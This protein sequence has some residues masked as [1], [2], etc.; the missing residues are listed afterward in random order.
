MTEEKPQ[1]P[2]SMIKTDSD[3]VP[4]VSKLA[5]E[6]KNH[7]NAIIGF[8]QIMSD[9][10]RTTDSVKQLKRWSEIVHVEAINLAKT[11]ERILDEE[12]SKVTIVEK[13]FIDFNV[14][15]Q[16]IVTLFQEQAKKQGVTLSLQICKNF[17]ILHTDPVL[18]TEMLNNLLNNAIKFTPK[19][20]KVF[21]KGEIDMASKALILVVQDTGKGISSDI[22]MAIQR[23]EQVTTSHDKTKFKGWGLGMQIIAEN[24]RKVGCNFEL[25]CPKDKG[26]VACLKFPPS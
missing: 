15:G 2:V 10:K 14:F 26:T 4:T 17:P 3:P 25:Y 12:R 7:L 16:K 8:T 5:H 23:G 18:L 9:P 13:E 22:L 11:C 24:A 1:N 20:G 6:I 21:L 19:G